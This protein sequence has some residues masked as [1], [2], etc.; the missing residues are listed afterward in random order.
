MRMVLACALLLN[1]G[2]G[3]GLI[4]GFFSSPSVLDSG[5]PP[6]SISGLRIW[7]RAD[8]ADITIT[9][10][11]TAWADRSGNG[12]V[13]SQ[14]TAADMPVYTA[15]DSL[16][17]N[18]PVVEFDGVSDSLSDATLNSGFLTQEATWIVVFA[19][20]P[21]QP[22]G[23]LLSMGIAGT[24]VQNNGW[25]L[26]VVQNGGYFPRCYGLNGGAAASTPD[27]ASYLIGPAT[28]GTCVWGQASGNLTVFSGLNVGGVATSPDMITGGGF[29]RMS[30]GSTNTSGGYFK[31]KIAEVII[32]NRV[33]SA[34]ELLSL[35]CY[36]RN[37]YGNVGLC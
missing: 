8:S 5:I 23:S 14:G 15:S 11:V 6:D 16:F 18:Q 17:G 4:F 26:D 27:V 21:G 9:T 29:N 24:P 13:F 35:S 19:T 33:V 20:D 2:C 31:G 25:R 22:N 28:V 36:L 1:T 3:S 34:V 37:R 12:N 10:G 32:Y 7:L 30:L